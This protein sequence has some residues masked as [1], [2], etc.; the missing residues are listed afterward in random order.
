[1][2]EPSPG[3]RRFPRVKAG[4]KVTVRVSLQEMALLDLS[5]VGAR[6]EHVGRLPLKTICSLHLP[7]PQGEIPLTCRVVHSA[8]S[9][10]VPSPDGEPTVLYQSGVEF[11]GLNEETR[12][13]LLQLLEALRTGPRPSSD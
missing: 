4:G 10:T 2:P 9:R 11:L 13:A 7:S 5:E 8:V 6:L 3:R 12:P 1:M